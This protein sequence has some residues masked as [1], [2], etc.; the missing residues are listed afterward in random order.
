M[1]IPPGKYVQIMQVIHILS[2]Q[3]CAQDLDRTG[4]DI[5][6]PST[7]VRQTCQYKRKDAVSESSLSYLVYQYI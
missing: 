7:A 4:T 6:I 5:Y 3:T 1:Q 2:S